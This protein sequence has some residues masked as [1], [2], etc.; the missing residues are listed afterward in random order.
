MLMQTYLSSWANLLPNLLLI[1]V[2][3]FRP[4]GLF[5]RAVRRA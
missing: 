2:L 5:G 3:L 4:E 1:A